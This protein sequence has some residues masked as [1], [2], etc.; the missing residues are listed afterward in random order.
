MKPCI[1]KDKMQIV[2]QEDLNLEKPGEKNRKGKKKIR[3][4]NSLRR[5][6]MF[7]LPCQILE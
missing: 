2:H 4:F 7:R 5:A 6:G 3:V 1:L